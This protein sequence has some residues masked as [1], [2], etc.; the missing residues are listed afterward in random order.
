MKSGKPEKPFVCETC[1]DAAKCLRDDHRCIQ[2]GNAFAKGQH[3][4]CEGTPILRMGRPVGI[5]YGDGRYR[6]GPGA[7]ARAC[8]LLQQRGIQ[9]RPAFPLTPLHTSLLPVG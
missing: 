2:A 7:V 8:R 4:P 1:I 3:A 9:I 6:T 5:T